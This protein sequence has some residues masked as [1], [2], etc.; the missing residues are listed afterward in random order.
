MNS[1]Q[2]VSV[3]SMQQ[4]PV[5]ASQQV[6][7]SAMSSQGGVNMLPQS[8]VNNIQANSNVLPQNLK[9]QQ[10]QQLQA[11]PH[12]F[13]QQY[14]QRHMQQLM[15]KQQFIQQQQQ[16][17]LSQQAKQQL[18]AQLQA[19]Q[20]SQMHQINEV[21]MKVR[22]VMGLKPGVF[23]QHHSAGPRPAYPHQQLKSGSSFPVSSPQILQSVSP[24]IQQHSSPQIDQQNLLT[25]FTKTGTPLQSAS[26]PFVVSSP[27]SPLAPSPM[28]P[29]SENQKPASGMSSLSNA[30]N[31]SHQHTTALP[32]G[33]QS[34]AIGTPGI[35][36]SPLLAEFSGPDGAHGV[37]STAISGK[38]TMTEQPIERL[39]RAVSLLNSFYL[40][41]I[42]ADLCHVY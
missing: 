22:P 8:N 17:Q 10:E 38:S 36:A 34:L 39:I 26:S 30:G 37:S 23:Q 40:I 24:Q 21:E 19:H 27:P 31:L 3:G 11:H 35:S 16:Q 6:N 1:L 33:A 25:S 41:S 18:P 9:Q 28:P 7:V 14:Q 4:N 42:S 5:S 20:M 15:Q 13:K 32:A 29:D 2:Q 12:Q